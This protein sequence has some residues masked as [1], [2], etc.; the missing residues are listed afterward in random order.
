MCEFHFDDVG[1][2]RKHFLLEWDGELLAIS[3]L[4]TTNGT[5]VNGRRIKEKKVLNPGDVIKAGVTLLTV[6]W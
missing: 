3:D 4:E 6:R 1:V 5:Q 2:S